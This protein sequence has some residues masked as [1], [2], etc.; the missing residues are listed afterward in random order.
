MYNNMS[1]NMSNN[2]DDVINEIITNTNE[3]HRDMHSVLDRDNNNIPIPIHIR[4]PI[5]MPIEPG[6]RIKESILQYCMFIVRILNNFRSDNGS[7]Y[8]NV[9]NEI[10]E[11]LTMCKRV[12]HIINVV[13]PRAAE[14]APEYLHRLLSLLN[15]LLFQPPFNSEPAIGRLLND[16]CY[17]LELGIPNNNAILLAITEDI[18]NTIITEI[19]TLLLR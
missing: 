1:N 11:N 14:L 13:I 8:E 5:P 3:L 9:S 16:L 18:N 2:M 15:T 19:D 10:E 7:N 6:Q 12:L 17:I 4:I